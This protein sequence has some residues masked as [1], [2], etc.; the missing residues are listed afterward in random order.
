[1]QN[2]GYFDLHC[3]IL[4][5]VDD[6]AADYETAC[7][8]L[9][10]S[11]SDGIRYICLT[12]HHKPGKS[13]DKVAADTAFEKLQRYI[14]DKNY[15]I[16]LKRG[17]EVLCS[18]SS[19]DDI[20]AGKALALCSS[21]YVLCEFREHDDFTYIK[22]RI[23]DM[24]SSGYTP[25]VAHPE[26]YECIARRPALLSELSGLCLMQFNSSMFV[27]AIKTSFFSKLKKKRLAS[28]VLKNDLEFFVASDAHDSGRRKP[29]ISEIYDFI[30]RKKGREFADKVFFEIPKRIFFQNHHKERGQS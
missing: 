14:S 12:P 28:F 11:Y 10:I 21:G 1:M 6:G 25:I 16:I 20:F 2:E 27:P 7:R 3:H 4:F 18:S 15:N 23:N 9:D 17:S 5:G 26:R 29:R 22:S 8:M 19:A 24:A 13:V 30:L